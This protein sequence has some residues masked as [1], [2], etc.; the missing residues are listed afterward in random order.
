MGLIGAL[1]PTNLSVANAA[2]GDPEEW[3]GSVLGG[4]E[5]DLPNKTRNISFT[6]VYTN[7][8]H[9]A[10]IDTDGFAWSW[11][12]NGF[13]QLANEDY[14]GFYRFAPHPIPML[15]INGEQLR[16]KTM[17]L[18]SDVTTVIDQDG[19]AWSYGYNGWGATGNPDLS[20]VSSTPGTFTPVPVLDKDRNHMVFEQLVGGNA[21]MFGIRADGSAWAWGRNF[22]GQLGGVANTQNQVS[23]VSNVATPVLDE[24]DVQ[25]KL[26][27]VAAGSDFAVGLDLDGKA[28]GWGAASDYA[29]GFVPRGPAT[30]D[31]GIMRATKMLDAGGTQLEFAE[32]SCGWQSTLLLDRDGAA[33]ALGNNEWRSL[34]NPGAPART[35]IPVPVLDAS[36]AQAHFTKA[37]LHSTSAF[38]IDNAGHVWGWGSNI[39]AQ[40]GQDP[41]TFGD[42]TDVPVQI[43]REPGVPLV[44]SSI[45]VGISHTIALGDFDDDVKTNTWSWGASW[46]GQLGNPGLDIDDYSYEITPVPVQL[47]QPSVDSK[48]FFGDDDTVGVTGTV[49]NGKLRVT[50]PEHVAGRVPVYVAWYGLQPVPS[51]ELVGHF[52][53]MLDPALTIDPGS[54]DVDGEVQLQITLP[55]AEIPLVGNAH[56]QLE[57]EGGLTPLGA[58]TGDPVAPLAFDTAGQVTLPVTSADAGTFAVTATALVDDLN[59]APLGAGPMVAVSPTLKGETKFVGEN[60]DPPTKP[61]TPPTTDPKTP[62]AAPNAPGSGLAATGATPGLLALSTAAGLL[63][64]GS[65]ALTVRSRLFKHAKP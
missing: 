2:P 1:M 52:T 4:T 37:V 15:D 50:A 29:N 51:Y 3:S 41:A 56:M 5:F 35:T 53:F 60:T 9:S 25:L 12:V 28:Y 23:E 13:G 43:F 46:F 59:E 47:A 49:V 17:A 44:A 14:M 21:F 32:V 7:G 36:G 22:Y 63:L 10:G 42:R 33:W 39:D 58:T 64:L 30:E 45:A 61:P 31:Q 54:T 62:P 48:V 27:R 65:T 26:S 8:N 16:P 55:A 11:G 18:G 34:G 6:E 19:K 57:L 24:A 38:G 40:L 20:L